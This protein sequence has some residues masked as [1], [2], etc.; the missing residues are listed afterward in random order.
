MIKITNFKL[1]IEEL[2]KDETVLRIIFS[3]PYKKDSDS[4][5]KVQLTP[6]ISN[7][8]MQYQLTYYFANRVVH[9]NLEKDDAVN[10]TITLITTVFKQALV[11]TK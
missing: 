5:S 2:F 10:E 9:S 1:L 4:F 6:Y 11:T 7:D 3:S 8:V